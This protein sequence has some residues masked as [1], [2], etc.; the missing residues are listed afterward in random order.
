MSFKNRKL[1]LIK[2][3]KKAKRKRTEKEI[4]EEIEIHLS[5]LGLCMSELTETINRL[6]QEIRE[7]NNLRRIRHPT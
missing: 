3:S 6:T 7:N 1:R 5:T 2:M 4:L